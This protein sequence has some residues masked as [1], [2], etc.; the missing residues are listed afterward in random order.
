MSKFYVLVQWVDSYACKDEQSPKIVWHVLNTR[1]Q[2]DIYLQHWINIMCHFITNDL[3]DQYVSNSTQKQ[4]IKLKNALKKIKVT[5]NN[6]K[7]IFKLIDE[8]S[9]HTGMSILSIVNMVHNNDI[10]DNNKYVVPVIIDTDIFATEENINYRHFE[11]FLGY[12]DDY[13]NDYD[14]GYDD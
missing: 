7:K 5:E 3:S 13:D 9:D 10:V 1:E 4:R 2:L 6:Y 11:R 8:I 12:G 14:Y